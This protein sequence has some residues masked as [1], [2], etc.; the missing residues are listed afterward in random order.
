[1]CSDLSRGVHLYPWKA[2]D[3]LL[4]KMPRRGKGLRRPGALPTWLEMHCL[5]GDDV[6]SCPRAD[7]RLANSLTW[8]YN[9]LSRLA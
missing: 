1:M 6:P 2:F 9:P 7:A 8:T 4:E 3:G 5:T